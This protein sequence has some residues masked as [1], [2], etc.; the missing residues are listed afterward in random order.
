MKASGFASAPADRTD[1][2]LGGL[3]GVDVNPEFL[4]EVSKVALGESG[5]LFTVSEHGYYFLK[6]G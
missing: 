2:E 4:E 3:G 6:A 5:G 1:G